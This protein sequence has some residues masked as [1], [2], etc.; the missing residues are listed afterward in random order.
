MCSMCFI[1]SII[2]HSLFTINC[3]VSR[4]FGGGEGSRTPVQYLFHINFYECSLLLKFLYNN[5]NKQTYIIKQLYKYPQF[6]QQEIVLF[7]T[8]STL[9][10]KA[11]EPLVKRSQNYAAKANSLLSAF[12]FIFRFF[13]VA[14]ATIHYSLLILL[15]Y[16]RSQNTPPY[17]YILV[18]NILFEITIFFVTIYSSKIFY[19]YRGLTM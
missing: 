14:E 19:F 15:K 8:Q 6:P 9:Y 18:Y 1:E 13:I 3:D 16:C 10:L 2:H 7:P 12:I 17:F 11:W 5:I 4:T